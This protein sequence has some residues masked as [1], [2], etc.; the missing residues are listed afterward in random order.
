MEESIE[1]ALLLKRE[2]VD[3]GYYLFKPI[4][5]IKGT[6]LDDVFVD[7]LGNSYFFFDDY[8][9]YNEKN[10]FYIKT[11]ISEN[12]LKE[13]YRDELLENIEMKLY[14]KYADMAYLIRYDFKMKKAHISS[15]KLEDNTVKET[16]IN[17][18]SDKTYYKI[19]PRIEEPKKLSEEEK[20]AIAKVFTE[21]EKPKFNVKEFYDKTTNRVIGQDD[22]I[23]TIATAIAMDEY[24]T[25]TSERN[26]CLLIGG[27]GTGKTEIVRC[28]S[29]YLNIPMVR[30][31]STQLTSPG[32]V[33]DK[34][35][36]VLM[37]LLTNANNDI[38]LAQRGIVVFDE[39]DKKG[40]K[41]N[42]DI[43]Q[44]AV[45]NNLLPFFDGSD[46]LLKKDDRSRVGVNFN[47]S[48][49][50]IFASGAFSDVLRRYS[51]QKKNIGFNT[52]NEKINNT[53]KVKPEDLIK[54]GQMPDEFIGR[55]SN[56]VQL[57][58][59][60]IESLST[61]L[62]KSTIS[63][64]KAE[65]R[66]LENFKVELTWEDEF[67][68]NVAKKAIELGTGARSLKNI[69]EKSLEVARWEILIN[70]EKYKKLELLGETVEDPKVYKLK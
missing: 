50:T 18:I 47:T 12:E 7:T 29:E 32:Y 11:I 42:N 8:N 53:D 67:I 51:L 19:L 68:E 43:S 23:K 9:I 57:N 54:Y 5:L 64:L 39:I 1:Y 60:T 6:R 70:P 63:P 14:D 38:N 31:D 35:E 28:V 37:R 40:S 4:Y 2:R 56:I 13:K 15:K 49:L 44:R 36:N 3:F 58:P 24:A 41:D 52:M 65:K 48:K 16:P 55:F 66:R 69:I 20:T 34:I 62:T 17:T 59:H 25:T 27:T 45:L 46:Y 10:E 61:I 22:A 21:Q 30:C 26:R 33:G